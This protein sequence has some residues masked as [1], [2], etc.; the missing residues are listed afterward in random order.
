MQKDF[1]KE[2]ITLQWN[3]KKLGITIDYAPK[4]H[5]EM[6]GE[7]IEYALAYAK[8]FRKRLPLEQLK[9]KENFRKSTLLYPDSEKY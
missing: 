9:K 2:K 4:Y 1:S 8:L 7:G 3:G 6:A 5:P